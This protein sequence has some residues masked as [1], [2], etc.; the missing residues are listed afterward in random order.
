M[1]GWEEQVFIFV[2]YRLL[3]SKFTDNSNIG[4]MP[5]IQLNGDLHYHF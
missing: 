5:Y 4:T 1:L 2:F 3:S